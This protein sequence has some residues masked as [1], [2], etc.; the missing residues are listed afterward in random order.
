M[1][2][3]REQ[4]R[5]RVSKLMV[6]ATNPEA[7]TDTWNTP[8]ELLALVYEVLGDPVTLDP[9]SNATS[10]V[11]AKRKWARKDDGYSRS[12]KGYRTAFVN[13]PYGDDTKGQH[14]LGDWL[15]KCSAEHLL[16]RVNILALIP[17]RTGRSAIQAVCYPPQAGVCFLK[18]R[19]TFGF[20]G[21]FDNPAQFSSLV[22]AMT[23]GP[24]MRRF[25]E[26]FANAGKVWAPNK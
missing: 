10:I 4:Q 13:P 26:V 8:P 11:H 19:V 20:K 23:D 7:E 22:V 5:K 1:T 14:G 9:C 18:G 6:S 2:T 24:T 17:A 16:H 15:Y 3:E 21:T 12:W 25:A